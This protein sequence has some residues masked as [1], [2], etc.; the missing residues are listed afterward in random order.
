MYL[1]IV[2]KTGQSGDPEDGESE[3]DAELE[4][5]EVQCFHVLFRLL[6]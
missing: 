1:I 5:A 4:T 3:G 2:W 6:F